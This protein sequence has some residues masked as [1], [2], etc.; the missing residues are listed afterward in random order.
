MEHT[1]RILVT[2]AHNGDKA[3]TETLLKQFAPLIRSTAYRYI[4]TG[5]CH[6]YEE[7]FDI[8][9][10]AF[11]EIIH[12][13]KVDKIGI[14]DGQLVSYLTKAMQ[15]AFCSQIR[16]DKVGAPQILTSEMSGN[17][18]SELEFRSSTTDSYPALL[19]V[20]L[21]R[22]LTAQEYNIVD[23][24]VNQD[25]TVNQVASSLDITRQTAARNRNRA[26]DKL[27][28]GFT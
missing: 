3:D 22:T 28:H 17:M 27:R 8:F 12:S 6:E 18:L 16:Q 15:N 11:L 2:S 21:K 25:M 7:A 26:F 13:M 19:N 23:M 5:L 4:H 1:L 14:T 9:Q 24:L 10:L 20:E